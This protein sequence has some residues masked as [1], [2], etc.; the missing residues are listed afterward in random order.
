MDY[1]PKY[2]LITVSQYWCKWLNKWG[3]QTNILYRKNSKHSVLKKVENNP[4][5]LKYELCTVTSFQRV[6]YEK[7]ERIFYCKEMWHAT[8]VRWSWLTSTVVSHVDRIIYSWCDETYIYLW[9]FSKTSKL[10]LII[11]KKN[12]NWRIFYKISNHYY[13]KLSK[14]S[15]TR[16][17]WEAATSWTLS[18]HGLYHLTSSRE[19]HAC[20]KWQ[21]CI[22]FYG[23]YTMW[24]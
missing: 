13:P 9:V 22:R 21:N 2:K 20:H 24:N 18:V 19:I 8:S 10:S 17:F 5:L 14:S 6:Q 16:T 1:N 23:I 11:R 3:E 15:K 7:E 4:P 12:P